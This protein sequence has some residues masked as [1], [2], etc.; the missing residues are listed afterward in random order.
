MSNPVFKGCATALVTPMNNDFS[1]NYHELERL[2]DFQLENGID[3][4]VVC[5]TT[6][7]AS[8]LN[9]NERKK[10]IKITVER[11]NGRVPVIAGTGSNDTAHA[12]SLTY[13]AYKSGADAVLLVT[14]YYNKTS[15]QGLIAH[16]TSIADS[17]EIPVILYNIPSRT[18]MN[19]EPETY[20]IISEHKNIVATKEASSNLSEIA[21]SIELC[22]DNLTFYCGNDDLTVPVMSLGALGL[23]SVVSNVK[24]KETVALC[25]ECLKD[26][27]ESARKFFSRLFPLID[28]LKSD[29]NPMTVKEAMNIYGFDVGKCRLPLFT[30]SEEKRQKINMCL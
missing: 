11:V 26:N 21:K 15:Q 14:P 30:I 13:D 4:L 7:E 8:T 1:I 20:R 17:V 6:G 10:I 12:I 18:S 22:K 3:A 25:H 19:I 5:G 16:F 24:P 29:I 27:F 9:D 28:A 23:I 2:I